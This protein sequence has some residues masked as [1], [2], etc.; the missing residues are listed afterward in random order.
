MSRRDK[1]K[2]KRFNLPHSALPTQFD[3]VFIGSDQYHGEVVAQARPDARRAIEKIF[4]N[5]YVAWREEEHLPDGWLE[6]CFIIPRLVDIPDHGLRR[7]LLALRRLEEMTPDQ[8]AFLM[9]ISANDHGSRTA[10]WSI[11]QQRL[12]GVTLPSQRN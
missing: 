12:V 6:F 4:P 9:M 11:T 10:F 7:D 3:A 2:T 8:F 5:A 1:Y